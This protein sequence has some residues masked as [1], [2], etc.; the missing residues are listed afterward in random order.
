MAYQPWTEGARLAVGALFGDPQAKAEAQAVAEKMRMEQEQLALDRMRYDLEAELNPYSI[1]REQAQARDANSSAALNEDEFAARQDFGDALLGVWGG[2]PRPPPGTFPPSPSPQDPQADLLGT[3]GYA[4]SPPVAPV[5]GAPVP[6]LPRDASGQEVVAAVPTPEQMQA[7]VRNQQTLQGSGGALPPLRDGSYTADVETAPVGADRGY[8]PLSQE[9][10]ARALGVGVRA[11]QKPGEAL[12]AI[13]AGRGA[14]LAGSPAGAAVYGSLAAGTPVNT[15]QATALYRTEGV[16]PEELHEQAWLSGLSPRVRE[17]YEARNLPADV[18]PFY[19]PTGSGSGV[20]VTTDENGRPVVEVGGSVRPGTQ[21][22]NVLERE[23]IEQDG[24]LNAI[25]QL[26]TSG[27]INS[28]SVGPV[29]AFVGSTPFGVAD[30]LTG[31]AISSAVN[32]SGEAIDSALSSAAGR[33]VNLFGGIDVT[34]TRI[35]RSDMALQA[36]NIA[37]RLRDGKVAQQYLDEIDDALALTSP[38]ASVEQVNKVLENMYAY[39]AED[40]NA[41]MAAL[42]G[43]LSTA[44]VDPSNIAVRTPEAPN[45]QGG[46]G[47]EQQVATPQTQDEYDALPPG[48]LFYDPTDNKTKRKS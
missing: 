27:T 13:T 36:K 43:G 9:A 6:R 33:D 5:P 18:A 22:V 4:G 44:Y 12:N 31:G 41:R 38:A 39:I 15:S 28:G 29:A 32:T 42:Q 48:T 21:G 37:S 17:A 30:E 40:R 10:V 7:Y 26:R 20:R 34:K 45:P 24:L 11:G 23:I 1:S 35:D 47:M 14:L 46:Q 2:L 8:V 25:A 19:T 16:P 3:S